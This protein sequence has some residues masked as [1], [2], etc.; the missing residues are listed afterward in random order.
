[1]REDE[2]AAEVL[3]VSTVKYKLLAF[4]MGAGIGCLSGAMFAV[5]IGSLAPTSFDILV[6]I[7]ALA[8]V[9]LGG[10]GSIPGVIVGALVLIGLPGFLDEFEEFRLLIYGAVLI[11]I[12]ILRPQGLV[13]NVRRMRE[14]HEED[15]EQD[16]WLREQAAAAAPGITVGGDGGA[17]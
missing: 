17:P 5:Q 3:G 4:A 2:L 14:L 1:M 15:V 9:I 10:M 12:M 6:S 7:T 16:Q 8:V 11:G 13:P